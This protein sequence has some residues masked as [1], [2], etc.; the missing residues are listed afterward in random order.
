MVFTEEGSTVPA[1]PGNTNDGDDKQ[2]DPSPTPPEKPRRPSL[3][4]VK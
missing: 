2:P 4:V 1:A 3:K